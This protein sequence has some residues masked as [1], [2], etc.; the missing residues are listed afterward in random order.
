MLDDLFALD[1]EDDD[2]FDIDALISEEQSDST[3]STGTSASDDFDI[4]ALISRKVFHYLHRQV[5]LSIS[6]FQVKNSAEYF[7]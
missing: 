7:T 2:S 5:F 3:P 6:K 1:D 4:D